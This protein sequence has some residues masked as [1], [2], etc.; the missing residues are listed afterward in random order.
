[1]PQCPNRPLQA[2]KY[3]SDPVAGE[4]Q[5]PRTRLAPTQLPVDHRRMRPAGS[6]GLRGNQYAWLRGS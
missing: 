6:E 1:M 5:E 2:P 3:L 4:S